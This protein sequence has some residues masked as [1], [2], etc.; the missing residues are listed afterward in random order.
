VFTGSG[1]SSKVR[2]TVV[3]PVVFLAPNGPVSVAVAA[4]T[5]TAGDAQSDVDGTGVGV[6]MLGLG[7]WVTGGS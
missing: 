1:P 2:A 4:F 5:E 6:G 7:D 3:D